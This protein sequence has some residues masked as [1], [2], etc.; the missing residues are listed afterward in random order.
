MQCRLSLYVVPC[1]IPIYYFPAMHDR[2]VKFNTNKDSDFFKVLR[3]RVNLHFREKDISKTA[4]FEMKF[5]TF[6]M[7]ALYIS[8]LVLMLTGVVTNIWLILFMWVLMGFGMSGIGLSIMHDA[9]HGSY[10]KNK[11][12][13]DRLGYLLNIIGGY[14]INWKIQ[15]NVLHHTYTNIDG[16][17]EDISKP[18]MRFSPNQDQKAIY[19]FQIFYAPILYSIMTLYW[20]ISKDI[21]GLIK[22]NKKGLLNAQGLTLKTG[23]ATLLFNKILYV[24]ILIALPILL[25]SAPWWISIIGFLI[26]HFICGLTLAFIFQPAHVVGGTKFYKPDNDQ[27]VENNWAIHQVL[28]TSN[29]AR[30]SGF[31][32]WFIG[33]LNHQIEH[34]LFP[35]ICH[36]HYKAISPIVEATAEEFNLPYH[37]HRT[38]IG[39]LRSH[40]VLLNDLGTG[41]WDRD[42]PTT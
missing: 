26:M 35:N 38:F 18:V 29:Y 21:E 16:Y 11:K 37:N 7:L 6:F 12:T 19:R 4:N 22:Y 3:Q 27:S 36:V 30:N 31:F 1:Q 25:V 8:P 28:T 32:G 13:N 10:S 34:H 15:H 33:G 17:D 14:H 23:L 5:K 40:F 9:N 24:G 41:K 39:A 20:V 42:N 2:T